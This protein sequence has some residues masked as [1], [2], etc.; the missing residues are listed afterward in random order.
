MDN[1]HRNAHHLSLPQRLAFSVG[2]VFNDLCAGFWFTYL[3]IFMKLVNGFES[4]TAGTL[5]LV[6]QVAD[7]IATP[8]IGIECDRSFDWWFCRYGRRKTWHL[9][10]T[11]C[12][13]LSFPFI[14]HLC[15]YCD[16]SPQTS[17]MVYY[18]AFIII[19]QFGW[20]AVQISHLSLIPDLTPVS[21]ERVELNAW[22]YACTVF[23]NITVFI[24]MFITLGMDNSSGDAITR[25]DAVAFEEVAF[26]ILGIGLVF[27]TI[28]HIGVRERPAPGSLGASASADSSDGSGSSSSADLVKQQ[29][30]RPMVWSNWFREAQFYKVGLLYMGTRLTINLTMV[31]IPNYLVESLH[32]QKKS[33]AYIPLVIYISGFISSFLM[34]F[35]NVRLGKRLTYLIGA[36]LTL[37]ACAW[38]FFGTHNE[39]FKKYG[40]FGVSVVI[41]M[42]ST[43]I[44]ITSLA[45][46]NDLIGSNTDSGAFVFGAMSFV[47]KISNGVSVMVI[48]NLKS[49]IANQENYYRDVLTFVCG[50]AI[51][52]SLI[53][54][55]LLTKGKIGNLKRNAFRQISSADGLP[56][57]G[58][59]ISSPLLLNNTHDD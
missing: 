17:Q 16:N 9:V 43:T 10:G 24:L 44:L 4:S 58:P 42:S 26:L 59:S 23:A 18:S 39:L 3:L 12:V 11:L 25:R 51:S 22:R 27:S 1:E 33:V 19:F 20:A 54:L 21:S 32:L 6:G 41:G 28:F 13:L 57:D 7:G 48:E 35:I 2:H 40:I 5:M 53:A 36:C 8:F 49:S 34:K 29:Q 15:I 31:Y 55:A 37:G 14:F 56:D 45:I 52:L 47:D 46:T 38:I 30:A 50:G